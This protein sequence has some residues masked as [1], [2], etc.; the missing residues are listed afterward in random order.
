MQVLKLTI[1]LTMQ[2][3]MPRRKPEFEK[4][5]GKATIPDPSI[6]FQHVKMVVIELCSWP[7]SNF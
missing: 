6:V 5:Q 3:I 7:G 1:K 2:I 4:V